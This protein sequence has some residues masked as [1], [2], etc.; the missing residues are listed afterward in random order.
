MNRSGAYSGDYPAFWNWSKRLVK[1]PVQRGRAAFLALPL[2]WAADHVLPEAGTGVGR[3]F[4]GRA[5][6]PRRGCQVYSAG[7]HVSPVANTLQKS[8]FGT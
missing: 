7:R 8:G 6:L 1:A 4:R 3:A 5:S 2:S